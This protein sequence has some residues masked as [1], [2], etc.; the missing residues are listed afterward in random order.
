MGVKLVFK[1]ADF[2]A[3]GIA[4]EYLSIPASADWTG[5]LCNY[6]GGTTAQQNAGW[7]TAFFAIPDG[8]SEVFLTGHVDDQGRYGVSLVSGYNSSN[9]TYTNVAVNIE[10]NTIT[11]V[12]H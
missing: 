11:L 12:F 9:H 10:A 6:N 4:P 7:D 1:N 8:A 2:S 3:N 5:W